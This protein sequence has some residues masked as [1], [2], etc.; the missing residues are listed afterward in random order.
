MKPQSNIVFAGLPTH[1]YDD[2]E[3]SAL[4]PLIYRGKSENDENLD[5]CYECLTTN[6]QIH[7]SLISISSRDDS[8][9]QVK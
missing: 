2:W 5:R 4:T 3:A 8:I 6:H 9:E 1:N 7:Q